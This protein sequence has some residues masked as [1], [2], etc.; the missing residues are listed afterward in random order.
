MLLKQLQDSLLISAHFP[1]VLLGCSLPPPPSP[2]T[3]ALWM[4]FEAW[5]Q[6]QTLREAWHSVSYFCQQRDKERETERERGGETER[7]ETQAVEQAGRGG[8]GG[9]LFDPNIEEV[10]AG[11]WRVQGQLVR[12]GEFQDCLRWR[13]WFPLI[14]K[15]RDARQLLKLCIKLSFSNWWCL[16]AWVPQVTGGSQR[17]TCGGQLS[18]PNTQ[19][20][21]IE[22]GLWV[23]HRP[24]LPTSPPLS[25]GY[26]YP[27]LGSLC[28]WR[29]H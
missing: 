9:K 3:V 20:P 23:C 7:R 15:K 11:G 22:L 24:S 29:R 8:M 1:T 25:L 4:E 21:G 19:T 10:E 28:G 6:K 18:P 12:H 14:W 16:W 26:D 2:P 17:A 27:H 5:K 13:I